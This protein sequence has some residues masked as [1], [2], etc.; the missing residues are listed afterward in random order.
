ME[1]SVPKY[2]PAFYFD[3]EPGFAIKCSINGNETIIE[4]NKEGLISLARHI[5]E[6]ADDDAKEFSHFH[7]YEGVTED[8]SSE[9]IIVKKNT[10][11]IIGK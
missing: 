10:E 11:T 6:L 5:L 2:G 3:W 4:A 1:I 9:L 7:L 8:G